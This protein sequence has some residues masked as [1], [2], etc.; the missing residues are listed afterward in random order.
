MSTYN[1]VAFDSSLEEVA[2]FQQKVVKSTREGRSWR[3]RE[4]FMFAFSMTAV[5]AIMLMIKNDHN[6]QWNV[7]AIGGVGILAATLAIPFGWFY[8]DRVRTRTTR[9]IAERLGSG[10]YR[11]FIELHPDVL[12]VAQASTEL[13][14]PWHTALVV[15]DRSDGVFISF[16]GGQVLARSR[17]FASAEHRQGFLQLARELAS[18]ASDGPAAETSPTP[19]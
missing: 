16:Q 8:D 9:M 13:R 11:Y 5:V 7:F 4:Q 10:P 14:F 6:L 19:A 18:S 1:H 2:S 15:E 12:R 17:G 3:R